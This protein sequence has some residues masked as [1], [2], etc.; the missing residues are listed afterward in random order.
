MPRKLET[1]PIDERWKET[2]KVNFWAT[3]YE[4]IVAPMQWPLLKLRDHLLKFGGE[5]VCL[6]AHEHDLE[7]ILT[8]KERAKPSHTYKLRSRKSGVL[9]L[10]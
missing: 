9:S 5:E 4:G 10:H 3:N 8:K 1:I 2:I 6:P 7:K